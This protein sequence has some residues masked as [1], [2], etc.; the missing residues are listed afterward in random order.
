M[1]KVYKKVLSFL[2]CNFVLE[3]IA[4][5]P[6]II[7][8]K[9]RWIYVK[10]FARKLGKNFRAH[11]GTFFYYPKNLNIGDN[12]CIGGNCIIQSLSNLKIG[13][14]VMIASNC[15][16]MTSN[17]GFKD[18]YIPMNL[19]KNETNELIIND[20][21]WIG[22]GSVINSGARKVE[23]AKGVIIASNSVVTKSIDIEYSIWGGVPAHF[24]KMRFDDE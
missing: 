23:I 15:N 11:T 1:V 17:H 10:I 20:D 9:L 12:A 24:I 2:Y 14:D 6:T 3:I 8:D 5:S 4:L 7:G 21:V 18:R 13:N 16:I 22:F 19:Q